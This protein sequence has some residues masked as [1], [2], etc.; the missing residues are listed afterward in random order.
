MLKGFGRK[1]NWDSLADLTAAVE[2]LGDQRVARLFRSFGE[3][4]AAIARIVVLALILIW[5]W[6]WCF[7]SVPILVADAWSVLPWSIGILIAS[8]FKLIAI[9]FPSC[10]VRDPRLTASDWLPTSSLSQYS[11]TRLFTYLFQSMR[12]CRF[13]RSR[14]QCVLA[15]ALSTRAWYSRWSYCSVR[16]RQGIGP[17]GRLMQFTQ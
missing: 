7:G 17:D 11:Y 1:Y 8:T 5:V 16:G 14:S 9:K 6:Y 13:A 10:S 12:S 15:I 2:R 4:R 3:E